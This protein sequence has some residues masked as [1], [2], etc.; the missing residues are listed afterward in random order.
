[1]LSGKSWMSPPWACTRGNRLNPTINTQCIVSKRLDAIVRAGVHVKDHDT[2]KGTH[3][4][5]H[6]CWNAIS[7]CAASTKNGYF[8]DD[9]LSRKWAVLMSYSQAEPKHISVIS[10]NCSPQS[11]LLYRNLTT[12][13]QASLWQPDR[14]WFSMTSPS[15]FCAHRALKNTHIYT[16]RDIERRWAGKIKG[17]PPVKD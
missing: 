8:S 7:L 12:F 5:E 6:T 3:A 2:H 16:H 1:M 17:C 4:Q 11:P 15:P 10:I 9:G 13:S 14:P